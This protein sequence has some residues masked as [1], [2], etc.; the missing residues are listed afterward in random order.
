MRK[1][2][3]GDWAGAHPGT[4]ALWLLYLAELLLS[5]DKPIP[6]ATAAQKRALREFKRRA[7]GYAS[8]GEAIWDEL[9]AGLWTATTSVGAAAAAGA[10]VGAAVS[11]AGGETAGQPHKGEGEGEASAAESAC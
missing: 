9:F 10:S 7:A 4:N 6:G 11:E 8:A 5:S 3:G 1:L 2:T